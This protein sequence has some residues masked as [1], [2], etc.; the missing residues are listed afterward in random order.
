M[1]LHEVNGWIDT[2]ER[3]P[4]VNTDGQFSAN[5][6]TLGSEVPSRTQILDLKYVSEDSKAPKVH[7]PHF[8]FMVRYISNYVFYAGKVTMYATWAPSEDAAVTYLENNY[9]SNEEIR[10]CLRIDYLDNINFNWDTRTIQL[11]H[12]ADLRPK[13]TWIT[14]DKFWSYDGKPLGYVSDDPNFEGSCIVAK[15]LYGWNTKSCHIDGETSTHN[16]SPN[17]TYL[18]TFMNDVKVN[19]SVVPPNSTLRVTS[20]V[21]NIESHNDAEAVVIIK[22]KK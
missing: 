19:G 8:N 21:L 11:D 2:F 13:N 17:D 16:K 14:E 15:D 6:M 22:E 7:H 9:A 3:T 10:R 4:W 20:S 1:E 5:V 18:F 12:N